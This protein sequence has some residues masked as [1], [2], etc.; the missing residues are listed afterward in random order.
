MLEQAF[1][2]DILAH[3]ADPVPRWVFA[4]WLDEHG[5]TARADFVRTQLRRAALVPDDPACEPLLAHERRLL[6]EHGD[7]WRAELPAIGGI[8]W[9]EFHGGFVEEAI[10][11]T[12]EAFLDQS[13]TLFRAAPVR[14]LRLR[15]QGAT[16]WG[17]R[18]GTAPAT[19]RLCEL[20][21]SNLEANLSDLVEML[22]DGSALEGLEALYLAYLQVRL[23]LEEFY[24]EDVDEEVSVLTCFLPLASRVWNLH[25]LSFAGTS[26]AY[27]LFLE[28]MEWC[29]A[30]GT[31]DVRDQPSGMFAPGRLAQVVPPGLHTLWLTNSNMTV[32]GVASLVTA[33][34]LQRLRVLY[35]NHNP[36]GD[37][38]ARLLAEYPLPYLRDL[39]LRNAELASQGVRA[40][41]DSPLAGQLRRV[42]LGGNPLDHAT[43]EAVRAV[44]GPRLKG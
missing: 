35:L 41:L 26:C 32:E 44:F 22:T 24:D 5:D 14:R 19:R 33:S 12:P 11:H 23:L 10:A 31:L 2:D 15:N 18:L 39:D 34:R 21:L 43:W 17:Q 30:L 8:E 1:R 27:Q 40:I 9:G 25:T 6:A 3:P 37:E 28:P 4:D 36:I 13:E 29:P 16:G 38:G 7:A 42:W 20:N